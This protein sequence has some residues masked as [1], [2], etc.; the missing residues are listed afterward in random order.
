MSEQEMQQD[1][2][3]P[4]KEAPAD[5]FGINLRFKSV[6]GGIIIEAAGSIPGSHD[7]MTATAIVAG[8]EGSDRLINKMRRKALE[9]VKAHIELVVD[10]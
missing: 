7:V 3:D 4:V 8:V 6:D 9:L 10:Q 2:S 5:K 1:K